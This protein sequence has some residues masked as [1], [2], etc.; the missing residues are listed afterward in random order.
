MSHLQITKT[1]LGHTHNYGNL[2]RNLYNCNANMYFNKKCLRK[3]FNPS[4]CNNRY[5]KYFPS[6]QIYTT[7]N[8][9]VKT[10]MMSQLKG[11]GGSTVANT[12]CFLFQ[13]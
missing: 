11:G 10:M 5:T 2:K 3:K 8:P 1:S 4:V 13:T 6:I 7:K 9:L 12:E